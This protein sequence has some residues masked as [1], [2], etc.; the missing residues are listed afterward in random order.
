MYFEENC[1]LTLI[2]PYVSWIQGR[3]TGLVNAKPRVRLG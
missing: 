3:L 1:Y 2:I